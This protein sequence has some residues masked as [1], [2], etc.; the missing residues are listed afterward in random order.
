MCICS[1]CEGIYE[2]LRRIE[3][4]HVNVCPAASG[5]GSRRA[6]EVTLARQSLDRARLASRGQQNSL[7]AA[8]TAAALTPR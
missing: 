7:M 5:V 2:T 1:W 3:R 6:W 4:A 8:G